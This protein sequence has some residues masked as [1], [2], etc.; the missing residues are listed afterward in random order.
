MMMVLNL[1]K[2]GQNIVK[3]LGM[4]HQK[5]KVQDNTVQIL[6]TYATDRCPK[7][8]PSEA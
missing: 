8:E 4:L 7:V 6:E 2:N 3:T 5:P 1:S